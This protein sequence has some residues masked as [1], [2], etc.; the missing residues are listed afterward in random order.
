MGITTTT[1]KQSDGEA[2]LGVN[3]RAT[4]VFIE[5]AGENPPWL[6]SNFRVQRLPSGHSSRDEWLPRSGHTASS[7]RPIA[8]DVEDWWTVHDA[9]AET[10]RILLAERGSAPQTSHTGWIDQPLLFF[11]EHVADHGS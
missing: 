2:N 4:D 11:Q 1:T 6:E 5:T 7:F 8:S 9:A 3:S 10:T